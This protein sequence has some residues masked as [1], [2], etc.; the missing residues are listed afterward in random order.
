MINYTELL[1]LW[2]LILLVATIIF[3]IVILSEKN[4]KKIPSPRA[5]IIKEGKFKYQCSCLWSK[6]DKYG[7]IPFT[8]C[9][10]HGKQTRKILRK[11]MK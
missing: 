8:Y 6:D 7:F 2:G 4:K 1:V 11:T 5:I 3:H 10:V 9:P